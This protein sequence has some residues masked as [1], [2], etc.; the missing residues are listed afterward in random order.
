SFQLFR[1]RARNAKPDLDMGDTAAKGNLREVLRL[2]EGIPL[3][4]ELAASRMDEF[5]LSEIAS[6]LEKKRVEFLRRDSPAPD[7]RHASLAACIEWTLNQLP[8]IVQELF[9]RL[10]VFAGGFFADDAETICEIGNA[11]VHLNVL[12]KYSLLIREDLLGRSRYRMLQ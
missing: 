12:M 8:P 1:T 10:S 3:S 9:P 6:E 2:T 11:T 5:T 7:R 4:I